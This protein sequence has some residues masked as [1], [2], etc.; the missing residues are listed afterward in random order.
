MPTVWD[1]LAPAERPEIWLRQPVPMPE[2]SPVRGERC[3]DTNLQRAYD[4]E[5]LGWKYEAMT[6][7]ALG[8]VRYLACSFDQRVPTAL[9]FIVYPFRVMADYFAAPGENA[10]DERTVFNTN[11]FSKSN[12]G[13][14]FTKVLSDAERRALIEYLKTL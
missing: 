12:G 3:F 10:V 2:A 14:E 4:Y 6:C 5:K 9:D 13:H 7:D 11:G 1:V 8:R